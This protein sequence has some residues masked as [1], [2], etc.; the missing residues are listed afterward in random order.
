MKKRNVISIVA[1]SL[2]LLLMNHAA[3]AEEA[4]ADSKAD[5]LAILLHMIRW[6][7]V[8]ASVLVVAGA[9]LFLR[10]LNNV[11]RHLGDIF[12]ERRLLLQ[13]INAFIRFGV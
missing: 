3:L 2:F 12:A 5:N 11:V 13:E 1:L 4:A 7:G 9:W 8:A 6:T 10:I